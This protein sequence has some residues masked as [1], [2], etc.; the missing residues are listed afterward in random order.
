[1]QG[2]QSTLV[3]SGTAYRPLLFTS[4]IAEL[5]FRFALSKRVDM[6]TYLIFYQNKGCGYLNILSQFPIEIK[7]VVI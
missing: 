5:V 2:L 4:K 1:M 3:F 7:V 6:I